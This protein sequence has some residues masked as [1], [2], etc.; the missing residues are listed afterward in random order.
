MA[1]KFD[2]SAAAV[3]RSKSRFEDVVFMI[4][5]GETNPTAIAKRVGYATPQRVYD[6]LRN[7]EWDH[8]RK[9]LFD[10]LKHSRMGN[11]NQFSR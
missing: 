9:L 11:R 5:H 8:L 3:Q 2:V 6:V 10:P 1:G 4:E 7:T